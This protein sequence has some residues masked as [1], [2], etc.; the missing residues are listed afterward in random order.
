MVLHG[1]REGIKTFF[2]I[3]SKARCRFGGHHR[4]REAAV[5]L[6][7]T[8]HIGSKRV[9]RAGHGL[10]G[11]FGDFF[12]WGPKQNQWK[13]YI[14]KKIH[15]HHNMW[16]TQN[17]KKTPKKTLQLKWFLKQTPKMCVCVYQVCVFFMG[18]LYGCGQKGHI[19][20]QC[21]SNKNLQNRG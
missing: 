17:T 10:L 19:W 7:T 2:P 3:P 1:Y 5:T 8:R 4:S 12:F 11:G 20:N 18:W 16:E 14:W 21:Y 13:T 6:T 15:A 9:R